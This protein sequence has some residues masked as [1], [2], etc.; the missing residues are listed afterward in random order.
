MRPYW[1][2]GYKTILNADCE[3]GHSGLSQTIPHGRKE[4]LL[5]IKLPSYLSGMEEPKSKMGGNKQIVL[6]QR[7]EGGV[8]ELLEDR[9]PDR[10]KRGF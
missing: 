9:L 1:G 2:G 7:R 8:F 4:G 5:G 6:C 10:I 3:Q